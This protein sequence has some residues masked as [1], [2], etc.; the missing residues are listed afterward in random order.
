VESLS[1]GK[2]S[3]GI[4]DRVFSHRVPMDGTIEVTW[5]CPQECTHCYNNLPMD[6]ARARQDEM[7]LEE[8][9]RIL[10]EIT[11]AGCLWLLYTGGE[12]FAR[13]DFLEI[14][15]YAKKKGLLITLFT[16]GTLITPEVADHLVQWAPFSIEISL[17]GGTRE[18]HEKITRVPGSFEGCMRG[19]RLL[20]ERKLPLKIKT[21]VMTA[22]NHEIWEMKRFVEDDLGLEFRF[23]GMVNPRI[24]CTQSPLAVRLDPADIVRLDLLDPARMAEW[25][26]FACRFNGPS[27]S[28]TGCED[29]YRCGG[30]Q[31]SFAINPR[32]QMSLCLLSQKDSYDLRAGSFKEGWENFLSQVR[33]KKLTRMTKCVSCEI[34]PM[35]GMCPANGELEQED[36]EAPVDFLCR[37]AHLRSLAIG[38]PA[39]P[40]GNCEY[41]EGGSAR[42]ELK[43]LAARLGQQM[44][45][46]GATWVGAGPLAPAE[47]LQNL[48]A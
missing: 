22:N 27:A 26:R 29:L 11:E 23:D 33:R 16:N 45:C 43:N 30:G 21:V 39:P 18:T 25:R 36:P 24:D 35:C 14:Y 32:G 4:H 47:N 37:V 2:F 44:P 48:V 1:F 5:R 34:Q 12:V 31:N 40:H 10:D 20:L 7:S 19:I 38:V 15:T 41:C 9:C 3:S 13:R 17:Y 8:H 42:E 46:G 6:D 28:A